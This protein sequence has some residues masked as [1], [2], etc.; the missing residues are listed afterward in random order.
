MA[1]AAGGRIRQQVVEEVMT[2][3]TGRLRWK[4]KMKI[5]AVLEESFV[6]YIYFILLFISFIIS[7]S[8]PQGTPASSSV[9]ADGREAASRHSSNHQAARHHG[10]HRITRH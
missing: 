3:V 5:A 10:G 4:R 9:E 8:R 6:L 1:V 2:V 7:L